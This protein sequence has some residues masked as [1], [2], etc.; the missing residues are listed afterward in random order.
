MS[1]L[2]E[3]HAGEY[4]VCVEN[5]AGKCES[6][7]SLSVSA[8]PYRGVAPQFTQRVA[9]QRVQQGQTVKLSCNIT[10]SPRPIISWFKDGQQLPNDD[11]YQQTDSESETSLTI[12]EALPTDGGV[13]ECVAK[14]PAGEC[15]CKSRLNV[16]LA[17]T[18]SE[19]EKG[20]KQEVIN[21]SIH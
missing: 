5:V 16:I 8:V 14:N 7:A 17:K 18:G 10:G 9:D 21:N 12:S 3:A 2:K 1:K 20:P 4:S 15:R 11:R 19:V 13:Y 6:S